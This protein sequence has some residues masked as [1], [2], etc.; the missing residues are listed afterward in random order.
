MVELVLCIGFLESVCFPATSGTAATG[1]SASFGSTLDAML[2]RET[3]GTGV[4]VST[5]SNHAASDVA[6]MSHVVT[7][8]QWPL[9]SAETAANKGPCIVTYPEMLT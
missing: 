2:G 9:R 4:L 3:E 8:T 6:A 1:G 7:I 5:L